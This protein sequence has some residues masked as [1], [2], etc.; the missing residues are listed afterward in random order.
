MGVLLFL[1]VVVITGVLLLY[2]R[3]RLKLHERNDFQ[4]MQADILAR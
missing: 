2:F 4:R 1:T 3:K